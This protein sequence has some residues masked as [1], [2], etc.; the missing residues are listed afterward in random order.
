MLTNSFDRS[1]NNFF[2]NFC[3]NLFGNSVQLSL[4]IFTMVSL[5]I[6]VANILRF[7]L[8]FPLGNSL[9]YSWTYLDFFFYFW[10]F[11]RLFVFKLSAIYLGKQ[12]CNLFC[13]LFLRFG[14]CFNRL[15]V[16]F[17]STSSTIFSW[18][19]PQIPQNNL[20]SFSEHSCRSSFEVSCSYFSMIFYKKK[21]FY[22]K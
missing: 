5:G 15:S 8:F 22:D 16:N 11:F 12:L 9:F 21:I 19:L 13:D 10:K 20:N 4:W 17:C 18:S 14:N 6:T 3:G 7:F 1:F 2:G